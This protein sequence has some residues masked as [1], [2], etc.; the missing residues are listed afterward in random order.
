MGP[1]R[2]HY[3][4]KQTVILLI[5]ENLS[6]KLATYQTAT[7]RAIHVNALKP[8]QKA[9]IKDDLIRKL[10]LEHPFVLVT[11]DDDF[12]KSWVHRKVPRQVI[13]IHDD[14]G[15][16]HAMIH[17]WQQMLPELAIQIQKT[18]FIECSSQGLRFPFDEPLPYQGRA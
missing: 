2:S 5:D 1:D 8:H 3:T 7:L 12:V 17:A 13:F 11:K 15:D 4:D 9:V 10:S 16:I 14:F 6:P 18:D